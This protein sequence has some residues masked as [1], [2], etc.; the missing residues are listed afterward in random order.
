MIIHRVILLREIGVFV[1]NFNLE[2]V[3]SEKN[4]I[5]LKCLSSILFYR[6]YF[7]L[8]IYNLLIILLQINMNIK[9]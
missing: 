5:R 3:L 1:P 2:L 9:M 8:S 4:H 6:S 7:I